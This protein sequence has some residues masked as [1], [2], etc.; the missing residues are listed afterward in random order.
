M[1]CSHEL[2][3]ESMILSGSACLLLHNIDLELAMQEA[4]LHVNKLV[5]VIAWVA[6]K[7]GMNTVVFIKIYNRD[8]LIIKYTATTHIQDNYY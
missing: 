6:V 7:F 5:Y 2:L 1:I 3:K 8:W 4:I